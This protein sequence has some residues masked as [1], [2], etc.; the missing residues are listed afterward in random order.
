MHYLGGKYRIAPKIVP[1]IQS[2][3]TNSYFEPFCG[4]LHVGSKIKAIR[5]YFS[6]LNEDLI[7]M[8]Q[9][10]QGGWIPP[11]SVSE[12]EYHEAKNIPVGS[13]PLRAFVGFG[14]SFSGKYWGYAR[15]K[16]GPR[17]YAHEAANS[18]VRLTPAIKDAIFNYQSY[19][20][21]EPLLIEP[22]LDENSVVYCD[23]PYIGTTG[24]KGLPKFNYELFWDFVR[25]VGEKCYVLVSEYKA[26]KDIT[27]LMEIKTKTEIKT[28]ANGR[29]DRI[30][31]IFGY[32]KSVEAAAIFLEK[33]KGLFA[34]C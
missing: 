7:V 32:G 29:E 4:A 10:L 13:S 12:E 25:R 23:P 6:D 26:P 14:S 18:L 1:L 17:D 9:G 20:V 8:Y 34:E 19:E 16:D 24:Y 28:S 15:R 22:L 3:V 11:F 21:I 30:E 31:R 27:T 33:D 5:S 2:M